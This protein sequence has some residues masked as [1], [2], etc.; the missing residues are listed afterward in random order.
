MKFRHTDEYKAW[1]AA[2]PKEKN[3]EEANFDAVYKFLC[4][5]DFTGDYHNSDFMVVWLLK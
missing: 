4:G 2:L 5:R 3:E 1:L